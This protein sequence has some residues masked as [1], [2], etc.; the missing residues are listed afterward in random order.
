MELKTESVKRRMLAALG[1]L[2]AAGIFYLVLAVRPAASFA[3]PLE[4]VVAGGDG[5]SEIAARLEKLGI[6]RSR[7]AFEVLALI[8]G[9]A[10]R[11]KPGT[12]ILS[13]AASSWEIISQL[14]AGA[15]RETQVTIPDGASVYLIDK[16]LSDAGVLPAG[17]FRNYVLS[18][19][20]MAEGKLF[21]DTYRFFLNS[22]PEEVFRKMRDNFER[23]ALP[24]LAAE[25]EKAEENLIFASLL[26][27]EVPDT[28]ERRLVAGILKKRLAAGI[29]LQVD[30]TICYLKQRL[31]N[32]YLPC[33]PLTDFDFGINSPYNT[34]LNKGL[35]P[36]P[37]GSPGLDAIRAAMNPVDSPYWFY[38]SDPK[39]NRTVFAKTLEEHTINRAKYL[40]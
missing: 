14:T 32:E 18:L 11:F 1:I 25:P 35:P 2:G 13:P 33:Y 29:P 39:T 28:N 4:F 8:S 22:S 34:Y 6:I 38:L 30:A 16:I 37:I 23:K 21:P 20:E 10:P 17:E 40:R 27:K 31:R 19:P 24:V 26:E 15:E 12:Y 36:G 9:S 5:F 3:D 7:F